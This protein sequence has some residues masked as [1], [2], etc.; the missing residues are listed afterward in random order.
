MHKKIVI[1]I[2]GIVTH[3]SLDAMSLHEAFEN[4]DTEAFHR[5]I[6]TDPNIDINAINSV[7]A[8]ASPYYNLKETIQ[9]LLDH[10][11]DPN[12]PDKNGYT[13]L[14]WATFYNAPANVLK[15]LEYGAHPTLADSDGKTP[16]MVARNHRSGSSLTILAALLITELMYRKPNIIDMIMSNDDTFSEDQKTTFH[17]AMVN[18]CNMDYL[19]ARYHYAKTQNSKIE[20]QDHKKL[21]CSFVINKPG[22]IVKYIEHDWYD[23]AA[24]KE[25]YFHHTKSTE[26]LTKP[27]VCVKVLSALRKKRIQEKLGNHGHANV[28][29]AFK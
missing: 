16:L 28:R 12:L 2:L 14:Y 10:G 1:I 26:F 11:A 9:F 3:A 15:L 24:I 6:E 13:A 20:E 23:E 29:F 8:K 17:Q 19:K 27:M 22:I 4:C 21:A 25:Y 7:L 5:I 18:A